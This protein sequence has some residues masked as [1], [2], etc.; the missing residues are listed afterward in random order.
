MRQ[1]TLTIHAPD[2]EHLSA[3]FSGAWTL[4][5]DPPDP[6]ELISAL[7]NGA[8]RLLL[9][10]SELVDWDTRLLIYLRPV[11]AAAREQGVAAEQQR[12]AMH[13]GAVVGDMPCG[14]AGHV[15]HGETEAQDAHLVALGQ[16]REWL[17]DVLARRAIDRGAGRVAQRRHAADMVTV[18]VRDV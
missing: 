5:A 15:E 8:D 16:A 17:G 7:Y 3:V 13:V 4:H 11:L 14:V 9:D 10:G 18:V 1:P 2:S 6:A 12:R